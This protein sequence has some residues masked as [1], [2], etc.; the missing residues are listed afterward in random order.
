MPRKIKIDQSINRRA[1]RSSSS[2]PKMLYHA[3][4]SRAPCGARTHA[5]IWRPTATAMAGAKKRSKKPARGRGWRDDDGRLEQ[6]GDDRSWRINHSSGE[7]WPRSGGWCRA[8]P[9]SPSETCS[10]ASSGFQPSLWKYMSNNAGSFRSGF[11]RKKVGGAQ[12]LVAL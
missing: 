2:R 8:W 3:W 1:G 4:S 7:A 9:S 6:A 5:G 12:E 11:V 10:S